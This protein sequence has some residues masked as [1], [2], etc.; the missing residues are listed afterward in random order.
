M[1]KVPSHQNKGPLSNQP[2]GMLTKRYDSLKDVLIQFADFYTF[3][4]GDS[5]LVFEIQT[6]LFC[7]ACFLLVFRSFFFAAYYDS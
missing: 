4:R 3:V 5:V 1:I 7:K 2:L 6:T